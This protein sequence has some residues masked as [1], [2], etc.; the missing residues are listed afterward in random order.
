MRSSIKIALL[1]LT[2]SLILTSISW[3]QE[4]ST[5]FEETFAL[6]KDRQEALKE[7]IPGTEIY[8]FYNC[9]ERQQAKE[10]AEVDSLLANWIRRYGRGARV[11]EIENRQALLQFSTNPS[12]TW[13]Y[14]AKKLKLKFDHQ[15]E[16]SDRDRDLPTTLDPDLL[17]IDAWTKRAISENRGTLRGITDRGIWS[18]SSSQLND[19]LL[20]RLLK[21]L[22]TSDVPNLP[23]LLI[24]GLK[25]TK[26]YTFDSLRVADKMTL[27]QLDECIRLRPEF[28]QDKTFVNQYIKRLAPNSDVEAKYNFIEKEKY[29]RRLHAFADR[30]GGQHNSLKANVL[31]SRLKLDQSQGR[32]DRGRFLAYLRLPQSTP[33][34]NEDFYDKASHRGKY[35]DRETDSPTNLDR[36]EK[37]DALVRAYLEHFFVSEDAITAYAEFIDEDYLNQVLAETKILAGIGDME[38]WYSL[39]DDPNYYEQIKNRVEINLSPTNKARLDL[40]EAVEIFADIKNVSTLLVKVYQINTTNYYTEA[41]KEV[42]AA[43]QIDGLVASQERT[44]N[45]EDSPLRRVRRKFAFPELMGAG[46]WVIDMIGNGISSRAVVAKGRLRF[47]ERIGSAGHVFRV[48]DDDGKALKN[49]SIKLGTRLFEAD[50]NSEINIPYSTR[51]GTK[52]IILMHGGRS[53][54]EEFYHYNER[55][56]L[57]APA[58]I[59]Q[60]SLIAGAEA[61]IIIRPAL[62]VNG[63][64]ISLSLLRESLLTIKSLDHFGVNSTIQVRDLKLINGKDFVHTIRVP[65]NLR[66]LSVQLSGAVMRMSTNS[67]TKLSAS[68]NDFSANG[69]DRTMA[70]RST[71]LTRTQSGYE[72]Q[73]LGKNGEP[74]ADSPMTVSLR[75]AHFRKPFESL[76]K[77]NSQGRVSLGSLSGITTVST[78]ALRAKHQV[79]NLTDRAAKLPA[80]VQ[81]AAGETVRLPYVARERQVNASNFALFEMRNSSPYRNCLENVKVAGGL[82]EISNLPP[83][84]YAL[85]LKAQARLIRIQVSGGARSNGWASSKERMLELSTISPMTVRTARIVGEN[86]VIQCLNAGSQTRVHVLATHYLPANRPDSSLAVGGN[87]SV[88]QRTLE[89]AENSYNSGLVISDEY[90]YI[91]DRRF[92]Q[93]FPG[94]ML[95][96]P[97]ILLNPWSVDSANEVIGLGGGAGGRFGGRRGGSSAGGA[98]PGGRGRSLR[99]DPMLFANLGFMGHPE[100]ILVNLSPDEQGKI[101]IPL[102]DLGTGHHIHILALDGGDHVYTSLLRHR[103]VLTN[104]VDQRLQTPLDSTKHFAQRQ[105][106]ELLRGGETATFADMSKSKAERFAALQDVFEVFQ[107]LNPDQG[108]EQF[109]FLMNWPELEADEKKNLYSLHACHELNFFLHQK[110]PKFFS[111]VVKP[112]LSNK[113]AMTFMDH[114]LLGHDLTDYLEPWAYSR[115][116]IV[117]QLLLLRNTETDP[118]ARSRFAGD[119]FDLSPATVGI[120]HKL[121]STVLGTKSLAPQRNSSGPGGAGDLGS[122]FSRGLRADRKRVPSPKK[123]NKRRLREKAPS[124]D[125][126]VEAE[127]VMEDAD[128]LQ[129]AGAEM[130]EFKKSEDRV[131]RESL[132]R[133]KDMRARTQNFFQAV[134]A[135][136]RFAEHNYWH[137]KIN[138]TTPGMIKMNGF[139]F[140]FAKSSKT[141]DFLSTRFFEAAGSFAEMLFAL[142]VL[143]LPFVADKHESTMENGKATLVAKSSLLL[144]REDISEAKPKTGDLS[145]IAS[146]SF[147]KQDDPFFYVGREKR[148]KNVKGEFL[149]GQVYGCRL[150][151]TNPTALRL[152]LNVLTQI[153]K[154]AI[155]AN[156]GRMTQN[157]SFALDGYRT[158]TIEF[159]FYFPEAGNF[160]QCPASVTS[161]GSVVTATEPTLFKVVDVLSKSDT[162]SWDSVSQN[163]T[164]QVVL[165]FL[166]ENNL[167]RVDLQKIAWR[168]K[169]A[170]F[171]K[172][173]TDLLK[174]RYHYS[175]V[176]WSY[177]I[178]HKNTEIAAEYLSHNDR[179]LSRCG[180][181]LDSPLLSIDPVER[182]SYQHIEFAPLV[183][184]RTHQFGSKRKIEN[185]SLARQF[186][187]LMKILSYRTKLSD[188]DLFS[189]TYYFLLQDRIGEAREAAAQINPKNVPSQ[190]QYDYLRA[191]LDFFTDDHMLARPIAERHQN[192]SNPRWRKKFKSILSQLDEAEG[193]TQESTVKTNSKSTQDELAAKQPSLDLKVDARN[194]IIGHQNVAQCTVSYFEMDIEFLFSTNP[195]V[196]NES[197]S[198][199]YVRPNLQQVIVLDAKAE[200]QVIPLPEKY[201]NSNLLVEVRGAGIVKRQTVF[202]NSLQVRMR[203]NY[204]QLQVIHAETT[205]PLSKVYVKVFAREKNGTIRFHKDGYTDI[206][207]RF[208]YASLS[209]PKGRN[210]KRYSILLMSENDGAMVREAASPTE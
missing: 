79:W 77:T 47:Q 11:E 148:A 33:Y 91:L 152:N 30:L 131:L 87:R 67:E 138:E 164:N 188:A 53:T 176:V 26:D 205:R 8:Y 48:L 94:N 133:D 117:E 86:L 85:T 42:D 139:W 2:L 104:A 168:L 71:Y 4:S 81:I 115:L 107:T 183:N 89:Q 189:V 24:R 102:K 141:D 197:G 196:R 127:E 121:F 187:S 40:G 92:A 167:R 76:L 55:Y 111:D 28:L 199:A 45:Y 101:S 62:H 165:D 161:D 96:R 132:K 158:K 200:T 177:G 175:G 74:I 29:L 25:K 57:S 3:S 78:K 23:A 202:A 82:L 150:V 32:Y 9:L 155:P 100:P 173:L 198:F 95:K 153:P 208:D 166:K 7:L 209:G 149:K 43:I 35:V 136:R 180:N 110:D 154:G 93:K 65:N 146:Q 119:L 156:V 142:S 134:E 190:L 125:F 84:N 69:I 140:D 145:V 137:R 38:R 73:V 160:S 49:A 50:D 31:Y 206:R 159:Y 27:A 157:T 20:V 54:L 70:T 83:G 58:Y 13:D 59:R 52:K 184:S 99:K 6:A 98:A 12:P 210:A 194:L 37:G 19:E 90:R 151:V 186:Q 18:L 21:R 193:K 162:K 135:T 66:G 163:A 39:L 72:L 113:A 60:E 114:W 108:L 16:V 63:V 1:C 109:S 179:F 14:L 128:E 80:S 192:H 97:E 122:L 88:Q 116:N 129:R 130:S 61:R 123:A 105:S 120:E 195:F 5:G 103:L 124:E 15:P 56:D 191:Y 185:T 182:K 118:T 174:K 203:E 106:I 17:S 22:E 112:Y 126:E 46:V 178:K 64:P 41:G 204:G 144:V 171:F 68:R 147:F 207:G 75:H 44:F 169:D 172:G 51:R 34:M 170:Q 201:R 143:D 181:Y 36:I 10:W